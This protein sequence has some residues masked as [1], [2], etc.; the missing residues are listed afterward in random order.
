MQ[1][2]VQPVIGQSILS[3]Y[4]LAPQVIFSLEN[5]NCRYINIMLSSNK[6]GSVEQEENAIVLQFSGS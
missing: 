5:I 3:Q 2:M 4:I 6:Q 1:K